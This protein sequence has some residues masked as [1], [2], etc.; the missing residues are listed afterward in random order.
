M[1]DA[2]RAAQLDVIDATCP[3]VSKVHAEARR[4]AADGGTIF[5]I[6]HAGHEEV[7]G[8]QGEAPEPIRVVEDVEDAELVDAPDPTRVAFLTQ[9]TLAVDET[10][11]VVAALRRR[12]PQL[13]GPKTDDICYATTNRQQSVRAVAPRR[14]WCSSSARRLL[15]LA[16]PGRGRAARRH[17]AYLVDDERD[18]DV[19]WLRGAGTVGLTAGASA[20]QQLVDRLVE[21]SAASGASRSRSA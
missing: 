13:R 20:P 21:R 18:V 12:F 2:A 17:P 10:D 15:E 11:E 19:A 7:E 4:F 14:T 1:R 5:L 16:A 8:T 9:T 6:G 3:L